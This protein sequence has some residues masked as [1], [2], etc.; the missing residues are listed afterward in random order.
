[1]HRGRAAGALPRRMHILLPPHMMHQFAEGLV[2]DTSLLPVLVFIPHTVPRYMLSDVTSCVM[3]VLQV[4]QRLA[5]SMHSG[6]RCPQRKA[7]TARRGGPSRAAVRQQRKLAEAGM[8]TGRWP[9][10]QWQRLSAGLV[11]L[12]RS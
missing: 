4:R 7:A 8:R 10:A 3:S 5:P 11:T 12:E 1:M 2:C 6:E 9:R